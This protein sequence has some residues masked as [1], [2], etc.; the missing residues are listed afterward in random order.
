M[1]IHSNY[2]KW[3]A[4]ILS[5]STDDRWTSSTFPHTIL[6]IIVK[7]ISE[8]GYEKDHMI[9]KTYSYDWINLMANHIEQYIKILRLSIVEEVIPHWILD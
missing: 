8:R 9:R 3:M 4:M 6:A 7:T 5:S 2:S 1:V